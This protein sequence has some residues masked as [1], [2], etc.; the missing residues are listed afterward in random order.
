MLSGEAQNKAS[1][2]PESSHETKA[3]VK[4]EIDRVFSTFS[5]CFA[6]PVKRR[7]KRTAEKELDPKKYCEFCG[8]EIVPDINGKKRYCSNDHRQ[9]ANRRM[10]AR[11]L[12]IRPRISKL[13][14]PLYFN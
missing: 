11:R 13:D 12:G 4:Y 8:I 3:P 9:T 14:D 6:M 1:I 2:L 7:S 5:A 10:L